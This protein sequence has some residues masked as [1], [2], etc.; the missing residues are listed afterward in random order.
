MKAAIYDTF[1]APDVLSQQEVD[2]PLLGEHEVLMQVHASPVGHGDLRVRAANFPGISWLPGRL[3]FGLFRPKYRVPG[4]GFAGQIT[5]VGSAVTRFSV[6]EH[7]FGSAMHSAQ[8][9]LLAVPED[10]ALARMPAGMSYEDAAALTAGAPTAMVFLRDLG[11]LQRGQRVLIIGAAG[12]VGHCA[13]QLATHFGAEVTAV[14]RREHFDAVRA[15]GAQHL[16]DYT[17]EDFHANGQRYDI[18]LD[19]PDA[20]SFRRCKAKL[21]PTGRYLSLHL[22]ARV[23]VQMM[24]S[25]LLGGRRAIFGVTLGTAAQM[26]E[27]RALAELGAIRPVIA[28]RFPLARIAEAHAHAESRHPHGS[29]LMTIAAPPP[30][31]AVAS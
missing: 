16:I 26:D 28:S 18:I 4:T 6:G 20:S 19:T 30:P 31:V 1:G 22:S 17:R 8:A 5:A 15:L 3:M 23:L 21:T 12:G 27:L 25:S 2:A 7:V 13:V 10:S 9:E 14:C 24:L 29:V 11:G